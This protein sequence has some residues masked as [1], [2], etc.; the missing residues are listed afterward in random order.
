MEHCFGDRYKAEAKL[1][2]NM[3]NGCM[4]RFDAET[5]KRE[6]DMTTLSSTNLGF[7]EGV[8]TRQVGVKG[9][10]LTRSRCS[11]SKSCPE[12]YF[13]RIRYLFHRRKRYF[14]VWP[15]HRR[16]ITLS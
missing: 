5:E 9:G 14:R 4:H 10:T 3:I 1:Y 13:R 6:Q 2:N 11:K 7:Q 8:K 15:V 12:E 16:R